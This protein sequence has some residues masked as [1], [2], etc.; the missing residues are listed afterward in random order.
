M[1]RSPSRVPGFAWWSDAGVFVT[2]LRPNDP[3]GD[4]VNHTWCNPQPPNPPAQAAGCG[5]FITTARVQIRA[6]GARSRHTGG[7]NASLC[8]GSVRF[9]SNSIGALTWQYLGTS[10][11][12]DVIPSDF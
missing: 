5:S 6:F 11:G 8:D 7:V 1:S 10:Q 4:Y 9:V 2:S 12:G 3:I